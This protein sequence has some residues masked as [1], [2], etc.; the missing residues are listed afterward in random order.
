MSTIRITHNPPLPTIRVRPKQWVLLIGHS[1]LKSDLVDCIAFIQ[2]LLEL[3]FLDSQEG[4]AI[5][6]AKS[7]VYIPL[8]KSRMSIWE[9]CQYLPES[10]GKSR[11]NIGLSYVQ[12]MYQGF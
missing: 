11:C 12:L 7:C 9:K 5:Y 6:W 8:V 4:I 3:S 10:L 1:T 2:R